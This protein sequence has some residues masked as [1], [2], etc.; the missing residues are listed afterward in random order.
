MSS[1]RVKIEVT[2]VVG[3]TNFLLVA[4]AFTVVD[5]AGGVS[6]FLCQKMKMIKIIK[7]P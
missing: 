1:L 5:G 2:V 3:A 4:V 7:I 6:E